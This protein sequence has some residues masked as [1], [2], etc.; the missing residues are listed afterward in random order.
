LEIAEV[1]GTCGRSRDMLTCFNSFL[2]C[3]TEN[4]SQTL[5]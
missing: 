3:G 5:Q 2:R 4:C 1:G